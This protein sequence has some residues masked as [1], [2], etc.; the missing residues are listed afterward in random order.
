MTRLDSDSMRLERVERIAMVIV[1][2]EYEGHK[3]NYEQMMFEEKS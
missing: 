2:A 3:F 1:M